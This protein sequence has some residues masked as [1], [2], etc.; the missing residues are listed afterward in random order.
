MF[1]GTRTYI[2]DFFAKDTLNQY[3]ITCV[4]H[5]DT[6]SPIQNWTSPP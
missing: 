4:N 5:N 1:F 2:D 6:E 3:A